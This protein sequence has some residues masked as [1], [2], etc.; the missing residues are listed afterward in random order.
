MAM[1]RTGKGPKGLRAMKH[2]P[3]HW[4]AKSS[5]FMKCAKIFDRCSIF[6]D[7]PGLALQ[8]SLHD[9]PIEIRYG[10]KIQWI[11]S[12]HKAMIPRG[13]KRNI[14][15]YSALLGFARMSCGTL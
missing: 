8:F 13:P 7:N 2:Q 10:K 6:A 1:C 3:V 4:K 11:A 5:N 12:M 14:P 15:L 9:R